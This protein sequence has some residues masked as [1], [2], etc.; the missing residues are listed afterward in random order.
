MNYPDNE[1]NEESVNR[2]RF[3]FNLPMHDIVMNYLT[4]FDP[5]HNCSHNLLAR[6]LIRPKT[7]LVEH[8]SAI[9]NAANRPQ[10][11]SIM[12]YSLHQRNQETKSNHTIIVRLVFS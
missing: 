2:S 4:I 11:D 6:R 1:K 10:N 3:F 8:H 9:K 12:Y 5:S 7:R